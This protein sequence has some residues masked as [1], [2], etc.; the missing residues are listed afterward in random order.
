MRYYHAAL[1]AFVSRDPIG[2]DTELNSYQYV[3]GGPANAFDPTGQVELRCCACC[4]DE[5]EIT[6]V[7]KLG[8]VGKHNKTGIELLGNQFSV[9]SKLSYYPSEHQEP[10]GLYWGENSSVITNPNPYNL[11]K[12]KWTNTYA[13]LDPP[14]MDK[15]TD[16]QI[17]EARKRPGLF[18][19]YL[20]YYKHVHGKQSC[21]QNGTAVSVT[22]TDVADL[23]AKGVL[24]IPVVG[25]R[26]GL[27]NTN[28]D[29][30]LSFYSAAIS[31]ASPRC[32]GNRSKFVRA[33]QFLSIS[34]G[35]LD[36]KKSYFNY[37][38]PRTRKDWPGDPPGA[39]DKLPFATELGEK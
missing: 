23:E 6:N 33:Q 17:Q 11:E 3:S 14:P 30:R 37:S 24:R 39:P 38:D 28:I 19:F 4:V 8:I 27:V 1:G 2:L 10:C 13:E 18:P 5:I 25:I 32:T 21:E 31:S 35:R 34:D 16:N 26:A 20:Q 9:E 15:L 7:G 36:D 12:N 29:R 22:V